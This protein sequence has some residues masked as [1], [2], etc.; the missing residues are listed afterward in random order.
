MT[1]Q[2]GH[3]P[4]STGKAVDHG[5]IGRDTRI[6]RA[7]YHLSAH[8]GTDLSADHRRPRRL[9]THDRRLLPTHAR[10][11]PAPLP[12]IPIDG[13]PRL[14]QAGRDDPTRPPHRRDRL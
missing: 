7:S 14:G 3:D 13:P 10:T 2:I 5:R 9:S 11:V 4:R 12:R 8:P 1:W 6:A